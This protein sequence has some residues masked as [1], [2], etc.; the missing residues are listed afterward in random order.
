MDLESRLELLLGRLRV[1]V[2]R[3]AADGSLLDANAPV[4]EF[5]GSLNHGVS[6]GPVRVFAGC[7]DCQVIMQRAIESGEPQEGECEVRHADGKKTSYF[8]LS[9]VPVKT[10]DSATVIDG[11]LEDITDRKRSEAEARQA[12]VLAARMG[13][14][15]TRQ[16]EVLDAVVAGKA[17]KV[18]ARDLQITEK[19]V[20][21][22]RAGAMKKLR[23]KSTAEL[24]RLVLA[25]RSADR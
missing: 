24:V 16:R 1:G 20:E 3:C 6:T 17:N 4:S 14:L 7:E 15:T 23:A 11:L 8:R 10:A 12:A 19:T 22:H 2:F 5:L 13:F 9:V 21:K 25:A 18:I